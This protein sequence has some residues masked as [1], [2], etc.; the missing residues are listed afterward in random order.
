MLPSPRL[1]FFHYFDSIKSSVPELTIAL[2]ECVVTL[3]PDIDRCAFEIE[4]PNSNFFSLTGTPT[5][6]YF[7]ASSEQITEEWV[8]SIKKHTMDQNIYPGGVDDE[9]IVKDPALSESKVGGGSPIGAG[10]RTGA[11]SV[12]G[13]G[14]GAGAGAGAGSIASPASPGTSGKHTAQS[15]GLSPNL[16]PSDS[17]HT[18]PTQTPIDSPAQSP[19]QSPTASPRLNSSK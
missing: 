8:R 16:S 17:P 15:P 13:S 4:Q 14:A 3:C 7:K 9:P 10:T 11:G 19:G 18:S 6:Y 5:K 1:A 12:V 2:H